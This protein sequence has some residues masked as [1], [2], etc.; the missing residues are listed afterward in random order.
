MAYS[1]NVAYYALPKMVES[2][3]Y[4]MLATVIYL[5]M[6]RHNARNVAYRQTA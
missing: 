3:A 6:T 1:S 4:A 5:G 2:L